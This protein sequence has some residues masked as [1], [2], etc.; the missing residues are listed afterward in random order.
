MLS[1][2][3]KL[4]PDKKWYV[5]VESDSYPVYSNIIQWLETLD[6]S[7]PLYYGS[8]VQIG[9]DVFAHGGSVFVMSKPAIEIGA[10]YY[11]D[12]EDDLNAWTDGHWAGDCVL[13]KTLRDAGVPLTWAFPM[14]QGGHPEKMDF[15]EHKLGRKLWCS[16]A[17]SYHHF[18]PGE[19]HRMWQFEQAW[20]QSRLDKASD[21]KRW[22]FWS[23]YSNILEHRDVFKN[24]VWP[25][26]HEGRTGTWNNLSPTLIG[27]TEGSSFNDCKKLCK[28]HPACLQF[29]YGPPGCSISYAAVMLGEPGSDTKSGWF[30]DRI[31]RWMSNLDSCGGS[32]GWIRP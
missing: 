13:G 17:L 2:L 18:S 30:L 7:K 12:H 8:E 15:T 27:E 4:R 24:F 21:E 29:V 31:E 32:E 16:P 9:P 23:D 11:A 26:I 6:P 3:L 28:A 10:Q 5:F 20:I 19:L 22:T 1:E 14:F 25:K